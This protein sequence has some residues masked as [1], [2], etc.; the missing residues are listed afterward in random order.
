MPISLFFAFWLVSFLLVCTP[1]ADWACVM[2]STIKHK[3]PVP[4]VAG[5]LMGYLGLV[6][7]VGVGAAALIASL[8]EALAVL[9]VVGALYLIWIGVTTFLHPPQPRAADTAVPA[10]GASQF[11][12]GAGVSFLNPKALL[13]YLV[14]LPQFTETNAVFPM[15]VQLTL[16]GVVHMVN[17]GVIYITVGYFTRKILTARPG[18]ARPIGLF[19]GVAMVIIGLLLLGEQVMKW[20]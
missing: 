15:V 13:T 19:S 14:L 4:A 20:V 2:S 9:T 12:S 10:S 1:G 6:A 11:W 3:S 8:P 7:M 16:L 5:L 17:C 18:A